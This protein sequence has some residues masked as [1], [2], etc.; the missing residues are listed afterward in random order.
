[1]MGPM[2]YKGW[3][4]ALEELITS[5]LRE[6]QPARIAAALEAEVARVAR[7]PARPRVTKPLPPVNAAAVGVDACRAGWVGVV[8]RPDTAPEV[9][10]DATVAALVDQARRSGPV[11]V[12][13]V[14]IPIGLP[15]SGSR[16]A[17]ALARKALPGKGSSVF[18]TLTRSAYEALTYAEA[19]EANKAATAGTSASAQAY[20]LRTKI[21]EVDS[22]VRGTPGVTVIEV[23]PELSF[24][25]M[26]GEPVG[27]SKKTQAGVAARRDALR[28]AG[29]TAPAWSR[30]SGFAEDDLLDAFAAAWTASRHAAGAAESLPEIPERFADGL[31]AAIW[32]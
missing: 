27:T 23:H 32:R 24:A 15:D 18:T 12:V 28:D 7:Q 22:W 11:S 16:Q 29:L 25:T 21:L 9:L 30:G 17:D 1:M 19:R 26:L 6:H 3:R 14:D 31:A 10:V 20:A 4:A 5:G 2:D 13:G 8:L